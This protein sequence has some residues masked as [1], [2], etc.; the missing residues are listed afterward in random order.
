MSP[1]G[2]QLALH[3]ILTE[4]VYPWAG[5]E[6]STIVRQLFA[7]D[8]SCGEC[9]DPLATAFQIERRDLRQRF[10]VFGSREEYQVFPLFDLATAQEK[11]DF[12]YSGSH[13]RKQVIRETGDASREL[14]ITF[15]C[16]P[17]GMLVVAVAALHKRQSGP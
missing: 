10:R 5:A 14:K 13:W 7:G 3:C 4:S 9:L 17:M 8:R 11:A 16:Q 1:G 15:I 6:T 12:Q 2:R